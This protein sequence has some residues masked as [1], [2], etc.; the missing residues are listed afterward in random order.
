MGCLKIL[1][2]EGWFWM[3]RKTRLK[4]TG[5]IWGIIWE[6]ILWKRWLR[7]AHIGVWNRGIRIVSYGWGSSSRSPAKR[8]WE[9]N[10]HEMELKLGL[11]LWMKL[12]HLDFLLFL[13]MLNIDK[14]LQTIEILIWNSLIHLNLIFWI[15]LL[16]LVRVFLHVSQHPE[17]FRLQ[18]KL[19]AS[20][21]HKLIVIIVSF[22]S[23]I[24]W[25]IFAFV[26]RICISISV[27]I[28][29]HFHHP[30]ILVKFGFK[31]EPLPRNIDIRQTG[32]W[33]LRVEL[34]RVIMQVV[35]WDKMV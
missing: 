5:S 26:I 21:Q 25:L 7:K 17:H 27:Q 1:S 34:W 35:F 33:L 16:Q 22:K 6:T 8:F 3:R 20:L 13:L 11:I 18:S 19:L 23:L 10:S 12:L 14:Q 15:F 29:Q 30:Q 2:E 32:N 24:H 28:L 9:S 4:D 31:L